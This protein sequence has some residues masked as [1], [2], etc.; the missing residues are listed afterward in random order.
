MDC[1]AT[2]ICERPWTTLQPKQDALLRGTG[3]Q[4]ILYLCCYDFSV[5]FLFK[6]CVLDIY[7]EVLVTFEENQAFN[8]S[9]GY[10]KNWTRN[11][12]SFSYRCFVHSGFRYRLRMVGVGVFVWQENQN[13]LRALWNSP[14]CLLRLHDERN[15]PYAPVRSI[16]ALSD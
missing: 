8:S 3:E 15:L 16:G 5:L 14:T 11:A 6:P 9:Q 1:I 4:I 12:D 7:Y 10:R 2:N 13:L